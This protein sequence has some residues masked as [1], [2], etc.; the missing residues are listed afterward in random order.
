M[1]GDHDGGSL[2]L[3]SIHAPAPDDPVRVVIPSRKG[4]AV[5]RTSSRAAKLRNKNVEEIEMLGRRRWKKEVGYH[6]Q[7]RVENT[8]FRY[9]RILGGRLR[10]IAPESQKR[11]ALISYEVLNRMAEMGMPASY[12]IG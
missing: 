4:A 2:G 11:E 1:I 3:G 12:S 9:K 8:F 7:G 5:S 10:T 6:Q